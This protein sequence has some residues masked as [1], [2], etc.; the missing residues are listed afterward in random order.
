MR[1]QRIVQLL[2]SLE[3]LQLG[4][5]QD[6]QETQKLQLIVIV[7][8]ST[9]MGDPQEDIWRPQREIL[10]LSTPMPMQLPAVLTEQNALSLFIF[11]ISHKSASLAK[12]KPVTVDK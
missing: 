2:A 8:C 5:N 12:P 10:Y 9:E 6:R 11:Q 1:N 7:T 3:K 4:T